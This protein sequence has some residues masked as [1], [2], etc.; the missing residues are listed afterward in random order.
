[1]TDRVLFDRR[2][3]LQGLGASLALPLLLLPLV[4]FVCWG[5]AAGNWGEQL[6][7][8]PDA[9]GGWWNAGRRS[10]FP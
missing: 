2:L 8:W 3:C 7:P 10:G 6:T 1:M 5:P 4:L 9:A